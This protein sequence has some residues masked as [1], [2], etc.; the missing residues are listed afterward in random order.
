M[1]IC[2]HY[3]TSRSV[4]FPP[5]WPKEVLWPCAGS[6]SSRV[7]LVSWQ[8]LCWC[9]YVGLRPHIYGSLFMSW[10][11]SHCVECLFR[12]LRERSRGRTRITTPRQRTCFPLHI[13]SCI[14]CD[15]LPFPSFKEVVIG[16]RKSHSRC[17]TNHSIWCV[18]TVKNVCWVTPSFKRI[19]LLQHLTYVYC[20]LD[21]FSI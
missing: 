18:N 1:I 20:R 10:Q 19:T 6:L 21:S 4:F 12:Q 16:V 3:K 2:D 15:H 17:E 13:S 8:W 5:L 7:W 11:F 9:T 14:K